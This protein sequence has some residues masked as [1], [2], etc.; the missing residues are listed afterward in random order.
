[1]KFR[2]CSKCRRRKGR[3]A[4]RR[5]SRQNGTKINDLYDIYSLNNGV[6]KTLAAQK[7]MRWG[8]NP[9]RR[10][11]LIEVCRDLLIRTPGH[12]D[13]LFPSVDFRD[14]LHALLTF[15]HRT[16]YEPFSHMGLSEKMKQ[17][18][19]QRL[20]EL[21]LQRVM[22]DPN[23]GRTYRVQRSVFKE[24]DMSGEDKVH[25]IFLMPH[26]IGHRASCLPEDLRYPVLSAFAIA[27]VMIIASR[28]LRSYNVVELRSIFDR[29]FVSLFTSMERIAQ[30]NHDR[31]YDKKLTKHLRNP[32]KYPRPTRFSRKDS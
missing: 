5:A 10:C 1:M 12:K 16:L 18:L 25:W 26:V 29:G 20:T 8:L 24:T 31:K 9:I 19:D 30:I 14:R 3:S 21:G 22:R 23:T 28:G 6:P 32:E 11:A 2:S 17:I 13:D 15:L 7:L 27:Q 4:F